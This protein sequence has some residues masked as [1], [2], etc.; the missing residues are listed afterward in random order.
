MKGFSWVLELKFSS[1]CLHSKPFNKG[2]I[3]SA[4]PITDSFNIFMIC[5]SKTPPQS[6]QTTVNSQSVS[7]HTLWSASSI[8][9]RW[10]ASITLKPPRLCHVLKA[11]SKRLIHPFHSGVEKVSK[12]TTC[13]AMKILREESWQLGWAAACWR[14]ES[15]L[16]SKSYC[17]EKTG[18]FKVDKMEGVLLLKHKQG[19]GIFCLLSM[20]ILFSSSYCLGNRQFHSGILCWKY[21]I[22]SQGPC[23]VCLGREAW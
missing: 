17:R 23:C 10:C 5:Y 8:V 3:S 4:S 20:P 11:P 2:T 16:S 9:T 12:E 15:S 19:L 13:L 22:S 7:H 21:C 6:W 14:A 1:S 18:M